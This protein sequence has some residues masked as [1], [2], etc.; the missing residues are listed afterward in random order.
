MT[1][2]TSEL[3]TPSPN[4]RTTPAGVCLTPTHDLT[5][6]RP[7]TWRIISIG[8]RTWNPLDPKMRLTTRPPRFLRVWCGLNL[9]ES[10]AL[11]W[12]F[13]KTVVD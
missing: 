8:F 13:G 5:C 2:S 1:R 6:N 3:K 10:Y 9:S 4:I 12:K 7:H 11:S